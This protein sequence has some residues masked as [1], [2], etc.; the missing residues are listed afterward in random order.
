MIGTGGSITVTGSGGAG[1]G[2]T[3]NIGVSIDSGAT[4]TSTTANITLAGTGGPGTGGSGLG[5]DDGVLI[6]A[7]ANSFTVLTTSGAIVINGTVTDDPSN[8]IEITGG[9]VINAT[10]SGSI[11]ENA[12]QIVLIGDAK[13]QIENLPLHLN[14]QAQAIIER[15]ARWPEVSGAKPLRGEVVLDDADRER[16]EKVHDKQMERAVDLLKGVLLYAQHTPAAGKRAS[17]APEVSR[18]LQP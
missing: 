4:V 14:A 18:A 1:G 5:S 6:Q 10:G 11:T 8:S 3:G 15:L 13:R 9:A 16:I 12:T 2:G 7:V 17:L